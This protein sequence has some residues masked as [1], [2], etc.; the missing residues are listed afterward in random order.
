MKSHPT[1]DMV[2][3]MVRS[4]IPKISL[5]TVYRNLEL[6]SEQG[7]IQKLM[8]DPKRKRFDGDNSM[9]FHIFCTVCGRID[10]L[11]IESE[12]K[13]APPSNDRGYEILGHKLEFFGKCPD[14]K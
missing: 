7:Q 8:L 12:V 1:A 14:C 6:L 10:D 13:W 3:E 11:D 5:G 2:Y 4:E 9:H